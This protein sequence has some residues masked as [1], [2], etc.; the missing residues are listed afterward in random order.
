MFGAVALA[1]LVLS[2][3][4]SNAPQD[5]FKAEGPDA[6]KIKNLAM[7]IGPIAIGVGILVGAALIFTVL[8]YRDKGDGRAAKQ[9][10]GNLTFELVSITIPAALL[11]VISV[12]TV[13]VIFD[14]ADKPAGAMEI[15]VVG[16]QWWWEFSYPDSQ[17][18][19]AN[20]MVIPAE[21]DVYLSLTSRD[22]IHSFW[23]PRLA[24]KKDAVPGR[25][26]KLNIRADHPGDYWGQ[27]SEFCGLS[28]ANM[29]MRVRVLSKADFAAWKA[30][31]VEERVAPATAAATAGER[32]YAAKCASCHQINGVLDAKKEKLLVDASASLISGAAPNLTHFASRS[33]FAGATF[34]TYLDDPKTAPNEADPYSGGAVLP[35]RAQ[36]EAWLRDPPKEI[37]MA[38]DQKRG[39]PNLHLTEQEI[40]DLADY[41]YSLK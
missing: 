26:H 37:P 40:N 22:V 11:I 4:A 18:V 16:Q 31:Q 2:G 7:W 15:S 19:T 6:R 41:L 34:A 8:K 5:T 28:H 3:C 20:E 33:V 1:G 10:H 25:V 23:I 17:I 21:T 12:F 14:L 29:R 9:F 32:V 36:L 39:M 27:C 13:S 24:G 35:N 38:S 30:N